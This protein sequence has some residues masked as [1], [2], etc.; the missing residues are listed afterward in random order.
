MDIQVGPVVVWLL[1]TVVAIAVAATAIM[2]VGRD[3][4]LDSPID[5]RLA[6]V[7][8]TEGDPAPEDDAADGDDPASGSAVPDPVTNTYDAIGGSAAIKANGDATVE[9][10]WATPRAGFR[11][12][13]ERE[14][15]GRELR[16]EFRSD[17]HRSRIKVSVEDGEVRERIEED[18][19]R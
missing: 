7:A 18:D 19:R 5:Q 2:Q 8:D 17:D 14:A 3:V 16:V 1:A 15:N 12:D 10:V 4:V 9:L 6:A 13:V 11:V